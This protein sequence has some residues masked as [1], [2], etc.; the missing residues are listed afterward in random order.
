MISVQNTTKNTESTESM[1][2]RGVTVSVKVFGGDVVS[3]RVWEEVGDAVFVCTDR[4]YENLLQGNFETRP[5]GFPK[6][7]ISWN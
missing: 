1:K 3:W 5:V 6:Q 2:N 7:A 4:C